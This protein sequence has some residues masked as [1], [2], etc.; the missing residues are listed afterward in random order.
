M[1]YPR[2]PGSIPWSESREI[3]I[4]VAHIFVRGPVDA[5]LAR[6][7]SH[8]SGVFHAQKFCAWIHV[9]RTLI[10]PTSIPRNR[11]GEPARSPPSWGPRADS[12][13]HS[14]KQAQLCELLLWSK[15]FL[16]A[17]FSRQD[18]NFWRLRAIKPRIA[19]DLYWPLSTWPCFYPWTSS[20]LVS[21]LRPLGRSFVCRLLGPWTHFRRPFFNSNYLCNSRFNFC[22]HFIQH[23][24]QHFTA[25]S[26]S[27]SPDH[28]RVQAPTSWSYWTDREPQYPFA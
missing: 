4:V 6:Q 16:L 27:I 13:P 14:R 18:L 9:E 3:L 21:P 15:T 23:P 26:T 5:P 20:V 11:G 22:F 12:K 24:L 1:D 7:S 10:W 17:V 2:G 28:S 8:T 19:F 25:S